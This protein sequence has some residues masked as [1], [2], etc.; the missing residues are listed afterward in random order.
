MTTCDAGFHCTGGAT[1]DRPNG[2]YNGVM[3]VDQTLPQT[4]MSGYIC[5]PTEY[6]PQDMKDG[7][8]QLYA[9]NP[10]DIGKYCDRYGAAAVTGN[11]WAGYYCD[12]NSDV[13]N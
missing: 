12:A 4:D 8:T 2:P 6:C 1:T 7:N 9:P 10:C 13:P 3:A 5:K 11:C